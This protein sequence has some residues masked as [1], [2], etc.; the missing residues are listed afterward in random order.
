MTTIRLPYLKIY[1]SNGGQYAYF[2]RGSFRVRL[3][4]ET[5]SPKFLDEYQKAYEIGAERAKASK[6]PA[7]FE[8]ISYLPGSMGALILAYK[9]S[10]EYKILGNATK[11]GYD[12]ALEAIS[13]AKRQLPVKDLTRAYVIGRRD[14]MAATPYKANY[15]VAV[16]KVL[17][18][19]A[20]Q[21]D[22]VKSNEAK[23][24]KR[25]KTTGTHRPWIDAEI[26]LFTGSAAG[27]FA[28]PVLIGLYTGQRLGDVLRIPHSAY[29]GQTIIL[30]QNKT[31]VRMAVPV[32]PV[33]KESLDTVSKT[34]V[35]ICARADG[36]S[37]KIDH[38]KHAFAAK[39]R[40]LGLPDDL[41]FH[42]LRHS[43]ASRM[44][45]AGASDAQ[46]QGVTGHK[47]RAMVELYTAGARQK[48]LASSAISML[49]KGR[50]K[51]KIV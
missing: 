3:A 7:T 2:R 31:G 36:H 11:A 20:M 32:H 15:F 27:N 16:L 34:A 5:G 30:T 23:S 25:L 47:T 24:V 45:E 44:A 46:I 19:W 12:R 26:E 14:K 40:A 22:L 39:R 43:A 38:F 10:H 21:R 50:I 17:L 13:P 8:S 48:A 37:W 41:H 42:G 28:L 9:K 29:D 18:S 1:E 33:L 4:A 51:N 6:A 49:P 35:T